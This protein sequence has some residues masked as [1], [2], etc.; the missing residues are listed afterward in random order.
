MTQ[1]VMTKLMP[2]QLGDMPGPIMLPFAARN[3]FQT[4]PKLFPPFWAPLPQILP[5]TVFSFATTYHTPH[6]PPRTSINVVQTCTPVQPVDQS[7]CEIDTLPVNAKLVGDGDGMIIHVDALEPGEAVRLPRE[8][9]NA[10]VARKHAK[11]ARNFVEADALHDTITRAGYRVIKGPMNEEILAKEYR[12]RLKGIDAPEMGMSYGEEA[13][14]A[15]RELI[16]GRILKLLVYGIDPYGRLLADVYADGLFIQEIMLKEGHA[17]HYE[18]FDPRPQFAE[19]QAEARITR[20]GLWASPKPQPPWDYKREE[21][22]KKSC[23]H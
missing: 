19:W 20:K 18:H 16:G 17:W 5:P 21:R 4:H 3:P 14:Q 23:T 7:F 12:V 11:V 6:L 10:T 22:R 9:Y 8:V 13:K 2:V 1:L 15:L